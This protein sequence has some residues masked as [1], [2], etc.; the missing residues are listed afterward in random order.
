M[1]MPMI[2]C[3]KDKED[4]PIENGKPEREKV[5]NTYT[6]NYFKESGHYLVGYSDRTPKYWVIWNNKGTKFL[7]YLVQNGKIYYAGWEHS[8]DT[9]LTD[10]ECTSKALTFD[11]EMPSNISRD[12]PCDMIAF[13]S[14]ID[15]TLSDGQI[16]CNADLFRDKNGIYL[17]DHSG[18][19]AGAGIGRS[20]LLTTTECL[21]VQNTTS[22]TIMVKHK[23]FEA[24]EK[25]YYSKATVSI[26]ADMR[27]NAQ[28]S[29][30]G[31]D[32]V[33]EQIKVAPGEYGRIYSHY[34]PT[35]KKMTDASL[36]LEINGKEVKTR[37][38]SSDV[39]I[40]YSKYYAM[41]VSWDGNNLDWKGL[42]SEN[43]TGEN[44]P[45]EAIDLGLSSGTLWAPY[46][47]GASKPEEI[48]GYY[49][50]G[51]TETKDSYTWNN[52]I[53]CDGSEATIHDIGK[54]IQGTKYDVAYVKW[55]GAWHMPTLEQW[56][57]LL[58]SCS[59][60]NTTINGV[61]GVKLISVS[62]GKSIFLPNMGVKWDNGVYYTE[63]IYCWLS[64]LST[65][66]ISFPYYL[67][68]QG[69]GIGYGRDHERFVGMPIRPVMSEPVA[70]ARRS[71]RIDGLSSP[72][73]GTT[74]Y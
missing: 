52:Y 49:A 46:N 63:D 38:I 39:D 61:N 47:M 12:I 23:G 11:I 58:S 33:S 15:A 41:V 32:V 51:E 18:A 29:S 59:R 9:L 28:G 55:G 1:C 19:K 21:Y 8:N 10:E 71:F 73:V 31:V 13:T 27:A 67:T 26:N 25:W 43:A 53:H 66:G 34:V 7:V 4:E 17:W 70:E 48:G 56:Q 64:T 35:G 5:F 72:A 20:Y 37:P 57:E 14:N 30:V 44:V 24:K 40:E 62:N 54:D 16:V 45:S 69:Q 65:N 50:W 6:F 68:Y 22:D 74:M 36:V 42:S 3:S 60:S 2:G